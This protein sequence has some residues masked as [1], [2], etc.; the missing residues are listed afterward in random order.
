MSIESVNDSEF[1]SKV[2]DSDIPVL[3][4]FTTAW[5]GPAREME[6][7]LEELAGEWSDQAS[8]YSLDVDNSPGTTAGLDI[9][10]VPT[11]IFFKDGKI[12][13]TITGKTTKEKLRSLL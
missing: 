6:P 13:Q 12:H 7:I 8:V 1:K 3:V 2:L 11:F 5:A 10:A 9:R 4:F